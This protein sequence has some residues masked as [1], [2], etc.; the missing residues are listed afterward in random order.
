MAQP[1]LLQALTVLNSRIESLIEDRNALRAKLEK[2]EQR[3]IELENQ[4][5]QDQKLI[6]KVEKD[7]EYLQISHRLADSPDTIIAARRKIAGL[8][9]T[10]NNCIRMINEE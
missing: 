2:L 3:N 7:V 1:Q 4:H 5:L 10:I 9:R 6:E 8:I